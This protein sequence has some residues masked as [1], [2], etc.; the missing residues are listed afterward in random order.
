MLVGFGPSY[1]MII[2]IMLS[3]VLASI[4]DID[5]RISLLSHRG[6]THTILFALIMGIFFSL[7]FVFGNYGSYFWIGFLGGF[8]SVMIH[9]F[10]DMMTYHRFKP[11]WPFSKKEIAFGLFL[12]NNFYANR[13][14]LVLGVFAFSYYIYSHIEI[15]K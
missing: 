3:S 8:S 10:G 4:S 5:L 14:F 2:I 11:L 13:G 9:M 15:I 12:A 7:I 6:F 1:S